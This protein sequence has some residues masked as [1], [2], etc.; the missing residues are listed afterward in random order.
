MCFHLRMQFILMGK[1]NIRVVHKFFLVNDILKSVAE[2][3]AW[4]GIRSR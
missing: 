3:E 1:N 4:L 2:Y